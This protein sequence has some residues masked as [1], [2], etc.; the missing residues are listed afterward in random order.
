MSLWRFD[1][2]ATYP[3]VGGRARLDGASSKKGKHTGVA[4]NFYSRKALEK[5]K[6][7]KSTN[8]EN[9]GLGVVYVRGRY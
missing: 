8:S 6:R 7:R 3:S 2:V 4:T 5:P 9:E 1:D